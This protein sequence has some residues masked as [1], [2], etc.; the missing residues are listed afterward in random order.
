[1]KRSLDWLLL[2]PYFLAACLSLT[3]IFSIAPENFGQQVFSFLLGLLLFIYLA[4][5]DYSLYQA[6]G[7]SSYVLAIILLLVTLF[8]G[9]GIRGSVR[10][11]DIFGFSFQA[12]EF[13]KPLLILAFPYFLT[14]FPP[15]DLKNVLKNLLVLAIPVFLIYRQPDLGTTLTISILWLAQLFVAGT[16]NWILAVSGAISLLLAKFSHLFLQ[17]YQL[18]RF[19]AYLDPSRDPLGS[20]YNVIQSIIAVGSGG[21]FGKGLGHGTQSHLRFL[22]ERHTDFI[23]ASLAEEL[24]LVGGLFVI[25]LL[26]T[27]LIRLLNHLLRSPDAHNRLILTGIFAV[28][29]FQTFINIGMNIGLAPVTGITLPLISYGGSS[30][31]A[32]AISLGIASSL[33]RSLISTPSIEIT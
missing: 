13:S 12:S 10:W 5:Q 3:M 32:T 26:S 23:F 15:T 14:R 22:P 33:S 19:E 4:K 2:A 29:C 20:G 28:L 8:L 17:D 24:G 6:L 30:V 31:I 1:M 11:L 27:I 9:A 21:I 7:L 25:C 16:K 18:Q